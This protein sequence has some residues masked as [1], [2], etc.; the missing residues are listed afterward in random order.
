LPVWLYQKSEHTQKKSLIPAVDASQNCKKIEK[1]LKL[2]A[3]VIIG[4]LKKN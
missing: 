3:H 1:T 4:F 2:C